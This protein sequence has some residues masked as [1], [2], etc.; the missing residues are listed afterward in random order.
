VA[1]I[2]EKFIKKIAFS[3]RLLFRTID[4]LDMIPS[5]HMTLIAR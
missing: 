1:L 4:S 2:I 3:H 5:Q